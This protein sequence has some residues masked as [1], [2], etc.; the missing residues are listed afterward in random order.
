MQARIYVLALL[1]LS[2]ATFL[3]VHFGMIWTYGRFYIFE[4]NLIILLLE[5]TLI[6]SILGFSFYCLVEQL[7][8]TRR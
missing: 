4:S 6:V 5:T 7:R 8:L 2:M 3:L 1:A